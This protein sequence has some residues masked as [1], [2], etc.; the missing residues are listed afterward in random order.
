MR[1]R[2]RVPASLVACMRIITS[3]DF[4]AFDWMAVTAS[5]RGRLPHLTQSGVIYFVTFRLA[6]SVP[7]EVSQRWNEEKITWLA[8]N[9]PPWPPETER[10]YHRCF[11]MRLERWL[12]SGLGACVLKQPEIRAEIHSSLLH[13]DGKSYELGDFVIMPNHVHVLLKPLIAVPVSTLLGKAK[14][15]SA[16]RINT[17]IGTH[18]ALWMDE[19]FDHIVRGMD[20]LKK[21]QRYIA[22]NP[23]KAGLPACEFTH[24]QRWELK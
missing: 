22:D 20:S 24:E 10:E 2:A 7:H 4:K 12:D 5:Y 21:F 1:L 11:T 14:G 15:A 6:D 9:P 18:G 17:Q 16:R 19:S 13:D 3:A 8:A 23:V